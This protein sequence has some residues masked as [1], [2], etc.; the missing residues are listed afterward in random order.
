MRLHEKYLN[1]SEGKEYVRRNVEMYVY[2]K[3]AGAC[4]ET[5][6]DSSLQVLNLCDQFTQF[7]YV[8]K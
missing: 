5:F 8:S 2:F 6:I 3:M 4:P 1:S 7:L